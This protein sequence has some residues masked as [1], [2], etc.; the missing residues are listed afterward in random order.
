MDNPQKNTNFDQ[1]SELAKKLFSVSKSEIQ[2]KQS[3]QK[4]SKA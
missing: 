4:P 1:F 3:K 2:P